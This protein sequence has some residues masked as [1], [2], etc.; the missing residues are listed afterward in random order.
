MLA[1]IGDFAKLLTTLL[2]T[3]LSIL[4][5]LPM[6]HF[7]AALLVGVESEIKLPKTYSKYKTFGGNADMVALWLCH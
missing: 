6:A 2:T 1:E 5:L 7:V 4:N 3:L